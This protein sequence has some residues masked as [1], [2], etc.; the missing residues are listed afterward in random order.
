MADA[1]L[2]LALEQGVMSQGERLKASSARTLRDGD[3]NAWLAIVLEEGRNRQIR[4]L[5][6][7]LDSCPRFCAWCGMAIGSLLLGGLAKG[8]WRMLTAEEISALQ[9]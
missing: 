1:K 3:K 6:A 2:L 9:A 4:R 5:L 7:A 8:Q